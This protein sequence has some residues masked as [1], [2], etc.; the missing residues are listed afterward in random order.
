MIATVEVISDITDDSDQP[1]TDQITRWCQAALLGSAQDKHRAN[2]CE[3]SV[4]VVDESVSASLNSQYRHK[5]NAT[6]VL[7]FPSD[8]PPAVSAML[9]VY[10]LG[11]LVICSAV[12]KQEAIS[13][14]KPLHDHWAHLVVHGV[15][16]LLG[17][18]HQEDN[19]AEQ[20]EALEVSILQSLNID[21]P[22]E[23]RS[24][25]TS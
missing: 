4:R 9:E 22:Y 17:F 6:N 1:D 24:L 2:H 18:D 21:D 11:D 20:M 3:I 10:P 23:D 14:H 12:V 7:S 8:L 13:Q 15:L 16:H 25:S 19:D 5:D